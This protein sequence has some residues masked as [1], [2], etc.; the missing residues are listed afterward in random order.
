MR[1]LAGLAALA[2]IL[3]GS[4][5]LAQHSRAT[6]TLVTGEVVESQFDDAPPYVIAE[7]ND[8]R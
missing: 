2:V 3:A 5:T 1:G 6:P 7:P 4:A 8:W